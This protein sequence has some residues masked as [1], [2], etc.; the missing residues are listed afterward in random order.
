MRYRRLSVQYA[1]R[2]G[3]GQGWPFDEGWRVDRLRVLV[4]PGWRPDA[5]VYETATSVEL[6]LDLAG[7]EE[8]DVEIQ[9]FADA[10]V[11]EGRRQIPV[12]EPGARYH[13]A[14]IRQGPFRVELALPAP[15]DAERVE[16]RYERGLLRVSLPRLEALR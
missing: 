13:V 3:V 2:V 6:V 7:V 11:V 16:A 12:S 9:L 4:Q 15:V 5:D 14:G 1:R 10:L 8:D